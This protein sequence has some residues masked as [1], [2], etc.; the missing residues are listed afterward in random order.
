MDAKDTIKA[1]L[2]VLHGLE[3][4]DFDSSNQQ[5]VEKGVRKDRG[6]QFKV[7]GRDRTVHSQCVIS[8]IANTHQ[9][10]YCGLRWGTHVNALSAGR[11]VQVHGLS[12]I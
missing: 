1:T 6:R 7:G 12:S 2:S 8:T 5:L 11:S 10:Y 4:T 3:D 9:E